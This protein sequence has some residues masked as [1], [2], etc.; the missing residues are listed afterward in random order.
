MPRDRQGISFFWIGMAVE[1][2]L[3]GLAWLGAWL[4]DE[5]FWNHFHW[6]ASDAALGLAAGL[7]MLLVFWGCLHWPIGPLARIKAIAEEFI[8]SLFAPCNVLELA[9]LSLVAGVGEEFLF[10]GVLQG[11]LI[12]EWGPWLGV[13]SASLLFG[14]LHALTATYILLAALLGAYLGGL[15]LLTDNLLPAVVAH[16]FYDFLA[17]LFLLRTHPA[18]ERPAGSKEGTNG[19]PG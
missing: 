2:S 18:P 7:P 16:A 11:A 15:F 13:A 9:A 14:L 12:R 10:R 3:V 1:G 8:R 17:L 4:L 5:P 6:S 19:L